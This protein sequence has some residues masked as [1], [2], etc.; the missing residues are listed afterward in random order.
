MGKSI[1]L[2]TIISIICF[3]INCPLF[4]QENVIASILSYNKK[5][6]NSETCEIFTNTIIPYDSIQSP[7]KKRVFFSIGTGLKYYFSK[8]G[9][10]IHNKAKYDLSQAYLVN[11]GIYL[12]RDENS[13]LGIELKGFNFNSDQNEDGQPNFFF[14]GFFRRNYKIFDRIIISPQFDLNCGTITAGAI[15]LG[16]DFGVEYVTDY[17]N[18]F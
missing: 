12:S 2:L 9:Y 5:I 11:F 6:S 4:A 7:W 14:T 16:F 3:L 17:F 1:Y 13:L 18:F 15:S 8:P 10:Y